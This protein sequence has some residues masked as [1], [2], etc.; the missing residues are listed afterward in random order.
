MK[1]LFFG[2]L[3]IAGL[4]YAWT[5]RTPADVYPV[6]PA[7]AYAQL[8][9]A[10]MPSTYGNGGVFYALEPTISG[11]GTDKVIV[12]ATGSHASFEC[13]V[14]ITP[15]GD[16]KSRL[17]VSCD[18]GGASDGAAKGLVSNMMRRRFI[19]WVDATMR[20]RAFDPNSTA[21]STAWPDDVVPHGN[22]GTAAA[23]AL[24]MDAETRRAQAA[25]AQ[26]SGASA[27]AAPLQ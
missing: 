16:A 4:G 17:A 18:G 9:A 6:K 5:S 14:S 27:P 21:V 25:S 10:K 7:D 22:I 26:D 1:S 3:V 23:D 11:N 13:T 12:D 8:T 2:G 19:E 24:K 15:D 20:G